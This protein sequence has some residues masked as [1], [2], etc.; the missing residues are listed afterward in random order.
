MKKTLCDDTDAGHSRSGPG[1]RM[2][3]TRTKSP[4]R[5]PSQERSR[6]LVAAVLEAAAHVLEAHG[7]EGATIARIAERAG[8]SVGSVYQYFG[9]KDAIFE[10]LTDELLARILRAAEPEIADPEIPFEIRVER[11]FLAGI[12]ELRPY[13]T[14]LRQLAGGIGTAFHPRLVAVRDQAYEYAAVLLTAHPRSDRVADVALAAR[15]LVDATEGL[16]LNL[17]REDEPKTLAREAV[18]LVEGYCAAW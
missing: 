9:T 5:T 16:F 17:R 18:R 15:V 11:G 8:V 2:A 1:I 6:A 7:Y 14:V 4:R 12:A 10:A 3:T 13:P